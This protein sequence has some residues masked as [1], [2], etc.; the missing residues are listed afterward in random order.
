MRENKF[1]KQVREKMDQLGFDPSEKVWTRV[2]QAIYER[3]NRRRP[4]LWIFSLFGL[5]VAGGVAYIGINYFAQAKKTNTKPVGSS[6]NNQNIQQKDATGTKIKQRGET[7][8]KKQ[9]QGTSAMNISRKPGSFPSGN[10]LLNTGESSRR[11][12]KAYIGT[13]QTAGAKKDLEQVPQ[14]ITQV[15]SEPRSNESNATVKENPKSSGLDEQKSNKVIPT[16]SV[17]DP[18]SAKAKSK[19][20]KKNPWSIIFTA[21]GGVSNINQ[22]PF[23]SLNTASLSYTVNNPGTNGSGIPGALNTPSETRA[24]FSFAAG[25]SVMRYLSKRVSWSVGLGYHYYSTGIHTG[26]SVDSTVIFYSGFAQ[27]TSV[28]SFYRNDGGKQFTNQYHFVE[29]PA[30]LSFQ[31]NKS[32]K[33]PVNWEAGISL[34]WLVSANAL[35]FDPYT[36]VYFKNNQLFNKIQWDAATAILIGFRVH[37]HS[38]LLGPQIE[39]GLT[40]LLKDNSSYPGHLIYFGLKC[41]FIP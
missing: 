33:N 29:L 19:E 24:G 35:Q 41:S 11:T 3:K 36:N 6:V 20:T 27:N 16:N 8:Q 34:A 12:K 14:N 4:I 9:H 31:L 1:E 30:N 23:H 26:I 17:S 10:L 7:V 21:S 39:Y 2:D 18:E 15:Q 25:V 40:S 28:N 32:R 37:N 5:L 38:I 22:S 13:D